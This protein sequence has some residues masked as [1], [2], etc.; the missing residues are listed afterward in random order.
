MDESSAKARRRLPF[1]G[2]STTSAK[3]RTIVERALE[4]TLYPKV[5]VLIPEGWKGGGISTVLS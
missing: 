4:R 2:G 3:K 5:E 1:L